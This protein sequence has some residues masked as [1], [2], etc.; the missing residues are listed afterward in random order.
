MHL[1][2][3]PKLAQTSYAKH[4]MYNVNRNV[5]WP[6]LKRENDNAIAI[7][8]YNFSEQVMKNKED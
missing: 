8:K 3:S 1:P 7:S 5:M 4:N 2:E 6:Y